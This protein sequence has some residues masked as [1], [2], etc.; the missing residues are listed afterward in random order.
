M[1][2]HYMG[3]QCDECAYNGTNDLVAKDTCRVNTWG[4][5]VMSVLIMVLIT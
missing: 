3:E 1:W 4:C 5:N 2:G